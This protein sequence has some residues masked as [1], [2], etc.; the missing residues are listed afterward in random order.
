MNRQPLAA[1]LLGASAC[2]TALPMHQP[3]VGLGLTATVG[4]LEADSIG[5][6]LLARL[7]DA[8]NQMVEPDS[9]FTPEAIVLADGEPR[10][11]TP[12]LAGSRVGGR[13]QLVS[14]RLS[15]RGGFVWGVFEYRWVPRFSSDA[16][17]QGLAT[18]VIGVQPDGGWRILHLHS[19][20]PPTWPQN[21]STPGT[22]E[23]DDSER[24]R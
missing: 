21:A 18:V 23:V 6:V 11:T 19:S 16:L 1:L 5:N 8:E 3:T 2:T 24:S 10:I 4:A 12:R 17:S 22:P 15:V 7:L 14:T 9:L 20:S 13:I